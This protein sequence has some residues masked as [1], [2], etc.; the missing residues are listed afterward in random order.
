MLKG[1]GTDTSPFCE[2]HFVT[3]KLLGAPGL[4]TR[5]KDATNGAPGI[6]RDVTRSYYADP[7]L[8]EAWLC[9]STKLSES[10]LASGVSQDPPEVVTVER[11]RT[12][13]IE[14]S[15]CNEVMCFG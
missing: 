12:K 14:R 2:F 3:K 11:V 10:V 9:L 4:T 5:S 7:T 6:A 13:S 8:R 1:H 15:P